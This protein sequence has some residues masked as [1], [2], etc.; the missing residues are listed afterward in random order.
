MRKL[1]LILLC[2]LM[3][4]GAVE[5]Q[6][7]KKKV[8]KKVPTV[9]SVADLLPNYGLDSALVSDTSYVMNLLE[10]RPQDYVALTNYCVEVRTKA[11][12]TINSI[13]NDYVH[14]DSLIW[15]DSNT[16]VS[17]YPIYE[18]RLRRLADFMGRMSIRYSRLEQQRVEAEKEA[19]R[20]KAIEDARKQQ[21]ARD[22]EAAGLRSNIDL[23]HRSIIQACDGAGI[24]DKARL[25]ELKDLYYSYL[26]VY[27]KYDLSA[28]HATTESIA[29]LD[30]LN[31]F[32]NDLLENVLGPNSLPFQIENFKNVLKVRCDKENSDVFRSYSRVF[33]QQNNVPISFADVAEYGNYINR[34]QTIINV[35]NRYLQT[36]DLRATI[37]VG[38]DRIIQLYGKKYRAVV[39]SYK[40]VEHSLNTVPAFTSN[41]ES[42]NFIIG[43][44]EFI[45]AQQRYVDD[46]ALLEDISTRSDS[47]ISGRDSKFRDVINAY[48]DIQTNLVPLPTFK[49]PEEATRYED[50]L[51]EVVKVQQ[52]YLQV[53]GMRHEIE[54]LDD[55][56]MAVRKVD[57]VVYNGYRLLRKQT[58][59]QPSFSTVERGRAFIDLLNEH[60]EMQQVCLT[61]VQ[62][63]RIINANEDKINDMASSYRN[64][65]K[66]YSR[67]KK[68]YDSLDE[69]ANNEDLRR[70]MRQCD[71]VM[72]MQEAFKELLRS[73]Y[74]SSSD[75][76]L[77]RETDI[78]KI[79]AVVGLK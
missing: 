41:A 20:Q 24:K 22:K 28:G 16:V 12:A 52:C 40:D 18:Y 51:A 68:A 49:N 77:K 13:E 21:E 50:A 45:S 42:I 27:N 73:D 46:Y 15:I 61:I 39:N 54:R 60:I 26:M 32:Q 10:E 5:A 19:A 69:I 35:Q 4:I 37:N 67:M 34:L 76:Q 79:K 48:R 30:E 75:T 47:I 7:P 11:Q 23:H 31:A 25:K 78:E 8:E 72:V 66:A 43:L 29:Q 58:D 71:N 55:S 9:V 38:S 57:R 6:K 36:L 56:L 65:S 64:I 2:L 3:S 33:K 53:I 17:D 63:R 70:Y 14:E 1:L 74:A 62:K 44:E 59:L